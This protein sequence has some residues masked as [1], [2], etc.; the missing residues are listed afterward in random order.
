[1]Q[2]SECRWVVMTQVEQHFVE[3]LHV[4]LLMPAQD[5]LAPGVLVLQADAVCIVG[6]QESTGGAQ[7]E[8]P[9][10]V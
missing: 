4:S 3:Q 8:G 6:R 2:S 5:G 1:M 9:G 10:R 7:Q